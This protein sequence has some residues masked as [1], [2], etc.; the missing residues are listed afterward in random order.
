MNSEKRIMAIE[1]ELSALKERLVVSELT[2]SQIILQI[3]EAIS[4]M[5]KRLAAELPQR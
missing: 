4:N 1:N 5:E 3:Q 2:T